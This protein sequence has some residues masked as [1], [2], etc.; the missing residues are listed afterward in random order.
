MEVKP[1]FANDSHQR[2]PLSSREYYDA[3]QPVLMA[4]TSRT[5]LEFIDDIYLE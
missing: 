3:A 1:S 5:K 4:A 2:D